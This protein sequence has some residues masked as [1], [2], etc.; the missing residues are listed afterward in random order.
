MLDSLTV[1][2]IMLMVSKWWKER[3]RTKTGVITIFVRTVESSSA[4]GG[5]RVN[6][7]ACPNF[8]VA[9][10]LV[11]TFTSRSPRFNCQ[12]VNAKSSSGTTAVRRTA[13]SLSKGPWN[14]I[15]RG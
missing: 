4:G 13:T 7:R 1:L 8:P 9:L 5:R 2:T 14:R 15:L 6:L 12:P 3:S 11:A 10:L